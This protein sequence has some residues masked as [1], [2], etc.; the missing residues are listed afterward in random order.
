MFFKLS[1][2]LGI[3]I[4]YTIILLS[5]F[6]GNEKAKKWISGR[7]DWGKK[8][9][10]NKKQNVFD[11]W[12]HCSSLGEFEQVRPIIETLKIDLD[13]SVLLS[14][15][16]PSGYEIR[17]DYVHADLVVYLPLD[18]RSNAKLFMDTCKPKNVIWVKYDLWLNFLSEIKNNNIPV[19]LI[20][21]IV[22]KTSYGFFKKMLFE[23]AVKYFNYIF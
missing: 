3:F 22:D 8:I 6:F 10:N 17:K 19:Y 13:Y 23:R 15:Y 1:Y 14:F 2:D 18:T 7:K 21:A 5:S 9:R 16:S 4:Y 11:F 20:G 12:V